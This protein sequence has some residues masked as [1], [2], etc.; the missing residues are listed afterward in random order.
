MLPRAQITGRVF[1]LWSCLIA[2]K[3]LD[4][5]LCKN[6][7]IGLEGDLKGLGGSEWRKQRKELISLPLIAFSTEISVY[8]LIS[9][10]GKRV[11]GGFAT[12][13]ATESFYNS[14]GVSCS[15]GPEPGTPGIVSIQHFSFIVCGIPTYQLHFLERKM[16]EEFRRSESVV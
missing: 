6:S 12:C 1:T 9:E 11:Y 5:S 14:I 4:L 2:V 8:R 15:L 7:Q 13:R 10:W 16:Y 3:L